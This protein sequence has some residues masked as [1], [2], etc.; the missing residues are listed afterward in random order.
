MTTMTTSIRLLVTAL[1]LVPAVSAL[2][3]TQP[4]A[5]LI[6]FH[7]DRG[8]QLLFESEARKA[9]F[10][11]A[12]HFVTQDN[13]SYCGVASMTMVLNAMDLSAPEVPELAPYRTF[14]QNNVLDA[15]TEEVLP[16]ATIRGQGMS[17]NQLAAM[18]ATKPVAVTVHHAGQKTLDEFRTQA[19]DYLVRSDH[20]V[21]VNYFRPTLGQEGGGHH[22]PLAAYHRD[23]DRFLILDVARYKYPPVWVTADDLF[24]AMS[25][26]DPGTPDK[27]RGYL[28]VS[29]P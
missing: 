9:Y 6:D 19:R 10:P 14:T 27:T 13:R 22:S 28:L 5:R 17:L 7:S 16:R 29:R 3:Q 15:R 20:F 18:L 12:S 11:L 24:A 1:L 8:E 4:S 25:T 2:G 23:S 26:R 21:L